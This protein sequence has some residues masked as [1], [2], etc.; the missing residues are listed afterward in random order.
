VELQKIILNILLQLP[1]VKEI[2]IGEINLL[3]WIIYTLIAVVL[4]VVGGL[5]YMFKINHSLT[6]DSVKHTERSNVL[7]EQNLGV[8]GD[9]KDITKE[10]L[11]I[12]K[13]KNS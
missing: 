3:H 1:D 13:G 5:I 12:L 2:P 6:K 11:I 4:A 10:L 8:I 7:S 9:L